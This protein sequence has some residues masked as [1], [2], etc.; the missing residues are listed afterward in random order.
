MTA[1]LRALVLSATTLLAAC[2]AA[3]VSTPP[4]VPPV[5]TALPRPLG[6]AEQA[7][8]AA[9]NQFGPLLLARV[10]AAAPRDNV[11]LSPLS[12]SMALGMAMNGAS[13]TTFDEMRATL[14]FGALPREQVLAASRDLLA[15]LRGLD[16]TVEL[17]IA[18]AIWYRDTFA[19]AIAPAFLAE[20]RQ[21]FDATA[22]GLD[23][24]S[25]SAVQAI[26]A[27]VR[28]GTNGR[29]PSIVDAI[30]P[31]MVMYLVNATYFKG[32]WRTPFD[33]ARTAPAPFTTL[34][35]ARVSVPMMTRSGSMRAAQPDGRTVVELGYGA[36][37]FAMT[38]VLPRAGESVNDLVASLTPAAWAAL[39]ERLGTAQVDLSLPR[40]ALRWEAELKTPL[41]AMG[42]PLAF[43]GGRADFTRLSP[44]QGRELFLS[45]VK[46]KTAVDV[47]EAGTVAAAVT[48]VGVGVTSVPQRLEVRVD[49]PFVVAIRERLSGALLFLGKVV[50]PGQG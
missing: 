24:T 31:A 5:L 32:F 27:W 21:Y 28:A 15:L 35:G 38:I 50:L 26:N 4:E 18:N 49:R 20:A 33:A 23:F 9:T 19:P 14:G 30:P 40:F 17:R 29:I 3:T 1:R 36:D 43:A 37:A 25:P 2:H 22:Q 41:A 8:V 13:G 7:F 12:A 48:S 10:N 45:T 16:A 44:T 6:A 34:D 42:M 46:Q 11:F 47:D 39:L